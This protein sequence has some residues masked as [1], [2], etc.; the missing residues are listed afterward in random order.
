MLSTRPLKW[1]SRHIFWGSHGCT[2]GDHE[3][4]IHECAIVT[5]DDDG[6]ERVLTP[7][8]QCRPVDDENAQ[9]RFWNWET[10]EWSEWSDD[11]TWFT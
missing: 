6:A 1:C 2:L 9:V 11:W 10:D 7:C 5:Y 8:S 4:D 3:G